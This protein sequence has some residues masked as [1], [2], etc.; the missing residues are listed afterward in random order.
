MNISLNESIGGRFR[1]VASSLAFCGFGLGGVFTNL[2]ATTFTYYKV[3][4][5]YQIGLITVPCLLVLFFVRTPFYYHK[6]KD[7]EGLFRSLSR[8]AVINLN[9]DK[10]ERVTEE[11][12][13]ILE[14]DLYFKIKHRDCFQNNEESK[15]VKR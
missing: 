2:L 5:Y 1:K 10:A 7:R 9:K 4:Y 8:I 13:E 3:F 6:R 11:I 15:I 12:R 14:M